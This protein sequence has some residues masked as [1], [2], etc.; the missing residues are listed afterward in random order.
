ML[1][2]ISLLL[3]V[4]ISI[5]SCYKYNKP[6]KPNNLI[7]KDKMVNILIDL[8]VLNAITGSDKK[9]LDSV[10]IKNEAYVYMK[11]SIDSTQFANS[12]AYYT[13]D[14]SEYESIYSKVKDSL[15]KLK[16]SYDAILEAE[17]KEKKRKKDSIK[18]LKK[19]KEA[20]KKK[21]TIRTSKFP[22]SVDLN[23]LEELEID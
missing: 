8:R 10:H 9:K 21:D 4:L 7:S 16:D 3:C 2:K 19:K 14:V 15:N 18:R 23:E 17:R 13:S 20:E 11:Y 1:K 5:S 12:N 6:E 22:D